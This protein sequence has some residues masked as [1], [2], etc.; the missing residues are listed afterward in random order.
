MRPLMLL[1]FAQKYKQNDIMHN[2]GE[3]RETAYSH[4]IIVFTLRKALL[5]ADQAASF[6]PVLPPERL[7]CRSR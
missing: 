4:P 5:E 6:D 7:A 2:D 3:W 1:P